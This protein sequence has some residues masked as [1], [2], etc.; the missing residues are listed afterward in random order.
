MTFWV[1]KVLSRSGLSLR[2]LEL[3]AAARR[4]KPVICGIWGINE[5]SDDPMYVIRAELIR[6]LLVGRH[7]KLDPRGIMVRRG[8]ITGKFDLDFVHGHAPLALRECI[9]EQPI[10]LFGAHLPLLDLSGSR[11]NSLLGDGLRIGRCCV[12]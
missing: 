2:E 6:D 1:T 12:G 3:V 11:I 4:G 8:R 9:I 5:I 10:Q 7:G